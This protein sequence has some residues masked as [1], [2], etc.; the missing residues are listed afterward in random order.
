VRLFG[1]PLLFLLLLASGPAV[2][3]GASAADSAVI[4]ARVREARHP[5]L[6][7]PRFPHHRAQ[8]ERL[9]APRGNAPLWLDGA[10]PTAQARAAILALGDAGSKGL[11][12]VDYD[13]PMLDR[14]RRLLEAGAPAS[15][16]ELALFDVAL[17]VA[18]LR[19]VSDLHIGKVNPPNLSF[20]LDVEPKPDDLA[21]LLAAAVRGGR[22]SELVGELEPGFQ[23]YRRL[24]NALHRYQALAKDPGASP[25]AVP[26]PLRPGDPFAGADALAR[27]LAAL[28]DLP[29]GAQRGDALY[30]GA[31]VGAVEHFQ[32][33]HGLE[34]DGVIGPATARAL[35]VPAAA[36]VRQI[37]L[38]LER[39]RWIPA[40][41]DQRLV[42]VNVPAFELVAFDGIDPPEG[43]ALSMRVVAGRA[44]RTPTPVLAGVLKTVVFSPYWNVPRSIVVAEMLPKFER[45]LGTLA[46]EQM[47]I[48][49]GDR[50]LTATRESVALLAA[51]Q[52]RLRQRP[53]PRNALGRVK[54]LFPNAHSVYLHDTPAQ[55]AFRATRRDFSHGCVRIEQPLA[56]ADW[57]LR[58]QPE[59]T[60]QRIAAL[61][62]A[63]QE[64]PVAVRA[65]PIVLLF[66]ATAQA[67]ADG[68]VAFY[69]DL[70]GQ[71]AELERQLSGDYSDAP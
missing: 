16:Q 70:Y 32:R 11:D 62:E 6:H 10:R 58:D 68:S 51:G 12:A 61:L 28:G 49:Q 2:G 67:H 35:A 20:R 64:T 17:S 22:V 13:G 41:G 37:Q 7:W 65:A 44:G 63:R 1:A 29:A 27:W 52:A 30:D 39:F 33:R 19:L 5:W 59:W 45:D 31:L 43:P 25:V 23:P 54:F 18:L 46:A 48:V 69:E 9:Y 8:L 50:I 4:A 24:L 34:G 57:V 47:E 60:H 53:G 38:A 26:T 40:L 42:F 56:F 55:T 71:D 14:M 3:A 21:A 15:S 66:Y 36:R